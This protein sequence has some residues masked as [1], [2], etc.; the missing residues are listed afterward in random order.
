MP[1]NCSR[2]FFSASQ[3]RLGELP[4]ADPFLTE[5]PAA[6]TASRATAGHVPRSRVRHDRETPPVRRCGRPAAAAVTAAGSPRTTTPAHAAAAGPAGQPTAVATTGGG[7]ARNDPGA[8]TVVHDR[9]HVVRRGL[10]GG[11]RDV[12]GGCR[13]RRYGVGAGC[14]SGDALPHYD[15]DAVV[16]R[17]AAVLSKFSRFCQRG[18][19][20]VCVRVFFLGSLGLRCLRDKKGLPSQGQARFLQL[21]RHVR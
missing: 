18:G 5:P 20:L 11:N 1:L 2:T 10:R 4:P 17:L 13:G 6:G 12:G 16:P 14:R 3:P 21:T 8:G 15:G 9:C 7:G 19:G